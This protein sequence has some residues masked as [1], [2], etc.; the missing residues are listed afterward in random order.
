[1]LLVLDVS[2]S[3]KDPADPDNPDGPTKLDLAKKAA[4]EALD[5]FKPE[6]EVGLRIF[7]TGLGPDQDQD[8]PRPP[9]DRADRA[10]ARGARVAHPGPVPAERHA[11]LLGHPA[12]L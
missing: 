2:G 12:V 1:M 5:Q 11:A 7:T 4:I 8:Y 3:M 9:A 10:E 6:D